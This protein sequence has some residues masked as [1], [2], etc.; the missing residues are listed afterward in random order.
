MLG[1]WVY[2]TALTK[3]SPHL[4]LGMYEM[5][6]EPATHYDLPYALGDGIYKVHLY[7]GECVLLQDYSLVDKHTLQY[8][9]VGDEVTIKLKQ[10]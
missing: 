6:I 1:S 5:V 9:I 8:S 10:P 7:T 3:D 2:L 4:V